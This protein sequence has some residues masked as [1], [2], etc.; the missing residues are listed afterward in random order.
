MA[1]CFALFGVRRHAL[2]PHAVAASRWRATN[3]YA[4]IGALHH[5]PLF[6][7]NKKKSGVAHCD[8]GDRIALLLQLRRAKAISK[9]LTP[10]AAST[11][12]TPG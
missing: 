4:G 2:L 12:R 8:V 6:Q 5:R 3:G 1:L 9:D 11:L 10:S 7:E